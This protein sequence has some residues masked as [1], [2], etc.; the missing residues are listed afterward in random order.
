MHTVCVMTYFNFSVAHL[1]HKRNVGEG[2][3]SCCAIFVKVVGKK[4]L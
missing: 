4:S 2:F 3:E 1:R